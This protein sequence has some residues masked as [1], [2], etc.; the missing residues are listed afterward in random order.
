MNE[1]LRLL[2]AALYS[3]ALTGFSWI[4]I[5]DSPPVFVSNLNSN[6]S[7]KNNKKR[8]NKYNSKRESYNSKY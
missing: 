7:R 2:A 4:P 3:R 8:N 1:D 6:S 5:I